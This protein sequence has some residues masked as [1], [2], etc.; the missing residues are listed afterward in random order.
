MAAIAF[1]GSY[2][3]FHITRVSDK[4]TKEL[5]SLTTQGMCLDDASDPKEVAEA[6][7]Q[8]FDGGQ[9]AISATSSATEPACCPIF[10]FNMHVLQWL[11]K[12]VN[13]R[14]VEINIVCLNHT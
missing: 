6:A 8:Y 10:T 13:I 1:S 11:Q 2:P 3:K 14:Y 4:Q 7:K 12:R 5:S 9:D